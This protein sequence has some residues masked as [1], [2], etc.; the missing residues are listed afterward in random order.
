[1][2]DKDKFEPGF[3]DNPPGNENNSENNDLP[4]GMDSIDADSIIGDFSTNGDTDDDSSVVE[5]DHVSED[6]FSYSGTEENKTS[7]PE[8]KSHEDNGEDYP[9]WDDSFSSDFDDDSVYGDPDNVALNSEDNV[10]NNDSGLSSYVP[11][12]PMLFEDSEYN[13]SDEDN[14]EHGSNILFWSLVTAGVIAAILLA[15]WGALWA[16]TG[17]VNPIS[18]IQGSSSNEATSEE[19]K[20]SSPEQSI[21]EENGEKSDQDRISELESSL[22]VALDDAQSAHNENDQLKS[23][24]DDK[25][26]M[27]TMTTTKTRTVTSNGKDSTKTKTVTSNRTNTTT[28]TVKTTDTK[29]VTHTSTVKMA[30]STTTK[31][32]TRPSTVKVPGPER[33]KTKTVPSGRVTVTTTV[34]ERWG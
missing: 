2:S 16:N 15:T 20:P 4:E 34:V 23:A 31:T 21:D 32:V 5:N 17:E 9:S 1:M 26:G 25:P 29:K 30:P 8:E 28:K 6:D 24:V 14:E 27:H 19:N 3:S 12:G 22:T 13:N 7:E 11:G 33:T 18:A 10:F